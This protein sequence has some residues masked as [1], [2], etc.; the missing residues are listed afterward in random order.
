MQY[1]GRV[2]VNPREDIVTVIATQNTAWFIVIQNSDQN[3]TIVPG[4]RPV[5]YWAN[6]GV[7]SAANIV[8]PM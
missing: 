8:P 1:V 2:T 7:T 6:E 4:L 3:K 5:F